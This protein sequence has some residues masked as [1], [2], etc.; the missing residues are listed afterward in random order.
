ADYV[1]RLRQF[2]RLSISIFSEQRIDPLTRPEQTERGICDGRELE[3][4]AL[5][6]SIRKAA[7]NLQCRIAIDCAKANVSC[8]TRVQIRH[9]SVRNFPSSADRN[10][11]QDRTTN[12]IREL[13][14]GSGDVVVR[15]LQKAL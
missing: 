2:D 15:G 14:H 10:V 5:R 8:F 7:G 6:A 11:C 1:Y 9:R 3:F 4:K 12:S 13:C